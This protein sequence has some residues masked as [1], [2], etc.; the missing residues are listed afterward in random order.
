MQDIFRVLLAGL[1]FVTLNV[2]TAAAQR[3]GEDCAEK[4]TPKKISKCYRNALL[5]HHP[6]LKP[7]GCGKKKNGLGPGGTR[8]LLEGPFK[9]AAGRI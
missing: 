3:P 7:F 4:A 6:E 2:G 8:K 9:R 5:D 1:I